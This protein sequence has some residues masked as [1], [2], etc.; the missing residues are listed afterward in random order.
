MAAA[1]RHC[2]VVFRSLVG[3]ATPIRRSRLRE[4][5]ASLRRSKV[6]PPSP[7]F[8][9]EGGRC[10][11]ISHVAD[12][13]HGLFL[14]A[15]G[16]QLPDAVLEGGVQQPDIARIADEVETLAVNVDAEIDRRHQPAQRLLVLL[17]RGDGALDGA[18]EVLVVE[19]AGNA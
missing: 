14:P 10:V 3:C 8:A 19:L 4:A 18:L 2:R 6:A 15:T 5:E 13:G 9:G 1:P 17:G 16:A 12:S 11:Y 7:R